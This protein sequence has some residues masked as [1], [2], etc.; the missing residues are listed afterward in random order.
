MEPALHHCL[1]SRPVAS[2]QEAIGKPI[3][4]RAHENPIQK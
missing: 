3:K 1:G 2:V 4:Q